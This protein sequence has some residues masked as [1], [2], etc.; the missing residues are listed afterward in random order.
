MKKLFIFLTVII[1]LFVALIVALPFILPM[2]MIHEKVIALVHEETN[3]TLEIN[4]QTSFSIFPTPSVNLNK[5]S[6]KTSPDAPTA[7]H[8]KA[9]SIK[10]KVNLLPLLSK[11]VE[12]SEFVI[13]QPEIDITLLKNK[14]SALKNA[15][16]AT[17][18]AKTET[19]VDNTQ[20]KGSIE[21]AP[22]QALPLSDISLSNVRIVD[23]IVRYKDE[24]T[25]M[26]QNAKK[27]NASV[28]LKDLNNPLSIQSKMVWHDKTISV[29]ADLAW[30][31]VMFEPTNSP[32][33]ITM[34]APDVSFNFDGKIDRVEGFLYLLIMVGYLV[35]LKNNAMDKIEAE[36]GS[37][38]NKDSEDFNYLKT[39]LLL[40]LGLTFVVI[41]ANYTIESASNIA[42][43]FGISEWIIGLLLV[44]FGTSLPE[45]V[46]SIKAA[47][48][49]DADMAIGNVIGSNIANFTVVL[50]G[51]AMI[52]PLIVNLHKSMFDILATLVLTVMLVFVAVDK[53][54]NRSTGIVFFIIF[55]IVVKNS[56]HSM[57]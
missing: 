6:F 8:I 20:F 16:K 43:I 32:V 2:N 48:K 22:K 37:E 3:G 26:V 5:I 36:A 54:Y 35:F 29:N 19:A 25:G 38:D 56:I 53:L 49:G 51:S 31:K 34:T 12:V 10:V 52:N 44:A 45:L 17:Q 27:I 18:K 47:K 21:D 7:T 14:P 23:G 41:G 50:G 40:L 46:V 13:Y 39:T 30:P 57:G 55:L 42:R 11:K 1:G 28:Q 15:K 33:K 24:K 4:G 9:N